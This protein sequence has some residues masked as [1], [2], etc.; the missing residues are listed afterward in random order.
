M[1]ATVA[2][3]AVD[4][5]RPKLLGLFVAAALLHT[6]AFAVWY[7][8]VVV[9]IDEA[10][11]LDQASALTDGSTTRPVTDFWTGA[12]SEQRASAY[13]PATSVLFAGPFW[14]AGPRAP[15]IVPFLSYLAAV[16]VFALLLLRFPGQP[17][18]PLFAALLAVY[19]GAAVMSRLAMSDLSSLLLVNLGWLCFWTGAQHRWRWLL[20]GMLAGATLAFREA[21]SMAFAPFFLGA[22]LRREPRAWQLVVGGLVGVLARPALAAVL[23]GE[24]WLWKNP[25]GHQIGLRYIAENW[26]L[27]LA[28]VFVFL[29][30]GL[31][32]VLAY[33]GP[34]RPELIVSVLAYTFFHLCWWLG[35]TSGGF[36]SLVTGGRHLLSV[37]P[38]YLIAIAH[39]WERLRAVL[40]PPRAQ[41]AQRL[42]GAALAIAL[43]A[44]A[45]VH[46]A[47]WH[48][49]RAHHRVRDGICENTTPQTRLVGDWS[50]MAKWLSVTECPRAFLDANRFDAPR[51][52]ALV[53]A[54]VD[55]R[56]AR[57]LR[58]DSPVWRAYVDPLSAVLGRHEA[59]LSC[60]PIA[61]VA[62][63]DWME[64]EVCRFRL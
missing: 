48:W 47:L 26:Q 27:Y 12:V 15:W 40:P 58:R 55:V 32:A 50:L 2:R 44:S 61:H 13:P 49:A 41:L 43:A 38:L 18:H 52:A 10:H 31:V 1:T 53:R 9:S 11:Y 5:P 42:V 35:G 23:Y 28:V 24:P 57:V 63:A 33:R 17:L 29:P 46:P 59:G 7:P 22:L 14:L 21:P 36:Y 45:G 64:L 54:G 4:P 56:A 25:G 20:A 51:V 37:V 3:A 8:D 19:P 6:I 34:R 30:A 62:A 39:G 16:G 60:E